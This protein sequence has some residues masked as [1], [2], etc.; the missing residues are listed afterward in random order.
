MEKLKK[1]DG[2]YWQSINPTP[3]R[4]QFEHLVKRLKLLVEHFYPN[5]YNKL[6]VEN[7]IS[8][9]YKYKFDKF[10]CDLGDAYEICLCGCSNLRYL[11]SITYKDIK[12]L[13]GSSCIEKWIDKATDVLDYQ[14]YINFQPTINKYRKY[15]EGE[16][17]K[18]RK[19]YD[20]KKC[21][22]R[23]KKSDEENHGYCSK[24]DCLLTNC[25]YKMC[26]NCKF[27]TDDISKIKC[28]TDGCHM[29]I[30]SNYEICYICF[31]NQ[32]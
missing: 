5:D 12:C 15:V 28:S 23:V 29:R 21:F 16:K 1:Y 30:D 10:I 26:Y 20:C 9:I 19:T 14:Q 31:K 11:F 17:E 4:T 3:P 24:C 22:K 2:K 13:I 25:A 18:K 32:Y 27:N 7:S 6:N 8:I